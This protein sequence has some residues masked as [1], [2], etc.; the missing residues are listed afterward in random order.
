M[1]LRCDSALVMHFETMGQRA[2]FAWHCLRRDQRG[3]PPDWR[4]LERRF[5]LSNATLYKVIW[6][7]AKRPGFEV[8]TKVAAAL[9]CSPEWLQAGSGPGPKSSWPVP[10]R[11]PPPEGAQKKRSKSGSM[12]KVSG[13]PGD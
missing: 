5:G 9:E 2:W 7:V 12:R 8:L 3:N 6:D 4:E 1:W 11:P 10:S 13:K